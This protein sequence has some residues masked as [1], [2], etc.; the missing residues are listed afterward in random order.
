MQQAQPVVIVSDGNIA[1]N[2]TLPASL[3][4]VVSGIATGLADLS[5]LYYMIP[6]SRIVT[7][8][9]KNSYKDD[10][11]RTLLELALLIFALWYV[12]EKRYRRGTNDIKLTEKEVDELI[13]EWTPE[14]LVPQLS[15][16]DRDTLDK[17]PLIDGANGSKVTVILQPNGSSSSSSSPSEK[18]GSNSNSPILG[19]NG[20]DSDG[21]VNGLG[22]GLITEAGGHV[23]GS[24]TTTLVNTASFNFLGVLDDEQ[25][26]EKALSVLHKYGVGTCGPPGFYGTLDIHMELEKTIA[27]TLGTEMAIIYSQGFSTSMSVI[28]CFAKKGDILICDEAI[29][30]PLQRGAQMSRSTVKYFRHNDMND[31][32]R[33]LKDMDAEIK[34]KKLPLTRRFIVVEGLYINTGSIAPLPQLIE[35]K[36]KYKYRLFVDESMS[37]GAIGKNG[38]GL[39]DYYNTSVDNIDILIGSMCNAIGSSGGFCAGDKPLIEHQRLSGTAYVFSASLPAIL[40]SAAKDAFETL[41]S[42]G[43]TKIMPALTQNISALRSALAKVSQIAIEGA[44]E[45]PLFHIR[46]KPE[47]MA[48]VKAGLWSRAESELLLQEVVDEAQKEGVLLTRA[49][50]IE[51]QELYPPAPSIRIAVSAAHTR[52]DIDKIA[53]AI[54]KA[55]ERT[56]AKKR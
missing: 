54:K 3:A 19:S 31:L 33:V 4:A 24:N 16:V 2:A 55:V 41:V 30:M 1:A 26:T 21:A 14:P 10:P 46:V 51:S 38:L 27:S 11:F 23:R 56:L 40:A 48:K 34:R 35:F 22:L 37:I 18:S 7:H 25:R 53:S 28:P 42:D 50:H 39:S 15:Q 9:V 20:L 17:L 43:K 49:K 6:G 8:Y 12:F 47:F 45:S 13:A 32:E 5:R 44:E 29:N 52:K 36:N